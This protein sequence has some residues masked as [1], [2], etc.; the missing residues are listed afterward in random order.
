LSNNSGVSVSSSN[1]GHISDNPSTY[2]SL[3]FSRFFGLSL[4]Y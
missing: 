4:C 1:T 2:Q 3:G